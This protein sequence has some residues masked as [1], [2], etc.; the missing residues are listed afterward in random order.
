VDVHIVP[1]CL[2]TAND[3]CG[4]DLEHRLC[5]FVDLTATGEGRSAAIAVDGRWA[6]DGGFDCARGVGAGVDDDLINVLVKGFLGETDQLSYAVQ[7]VKD[8]VGVFA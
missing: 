7:I 2:A 5:E 8:F 4:L 1:D 3:G 6:Y